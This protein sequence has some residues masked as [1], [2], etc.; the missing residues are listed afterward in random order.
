MIYALRLAVTLQVLCVADRQ[1]KPAPMITPVLV[2][3]ASCVPV[4]ATVAELMQLPLPPTVREVCDFPQRIRE[5]TFPDLVVMLHSL[6][7]QKP[8]AVP[9]HQLGKDIEVLHV[10]IVAQ[11]VV[12]YGV[13][14]IG[15]LDTAA[16]SMVKR[17]ASLA[18]DD[19]I[20]LST[21]IP[22]VLAV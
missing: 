12:L 18:L 21:Y 5:L 6:M 7:I 20:S 2:S 22:E 17:L 10:G 13:L 8:Y 19:R 9:V 4:V 15:Q 16:W 1:V 11:A 14:H 3:P